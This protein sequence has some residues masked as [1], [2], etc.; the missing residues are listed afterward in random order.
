M[1]QLGLVKFR[2]VRWLVSLW[3]RY[4]LTFSPQPATFARYR[5]SIRQTKFKITVITRVSTEDQLTANCCSKFLP[6]IAHGNLSAIPEN[7]EHYIGASV[8]ITVRSYEDSRGIDQP[9]KMG[10]RFLDSLRFMGSSLSSLV[11]NLVGTTFDHIDED[12]V[13]HSRSHRIHLSRDDIH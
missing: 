7:S 12:Y 8:N 4:P 13:D 10:L 11:S 1:R 2:C 5:V 9:L 6:V 3:S